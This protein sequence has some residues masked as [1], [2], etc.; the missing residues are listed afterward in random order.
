MWTRIGLA[1]FLLCGT[2]SLAS[3][4]ARAG[5]V[6]ETATPAYADGTS[7]RDDK[8]DAT[9]A[10]KVTS[11]GAAGISNLGTANAAAPSLVE[12]A[13]ASFSF[14]LSGN[15]RFTLGTLLSGEDQTN[16]LLMTSGGAVRI[17]MFSS[18]TSA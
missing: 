5:C 13:Q 2:W 10:R 12:A 9:G 11:A 16:N 14:D 7:L 6:V 1:L 8:C 3:P 18:V 4:E 17:T 15:A